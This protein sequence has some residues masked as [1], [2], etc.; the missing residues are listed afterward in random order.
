MAT[1]IKPPFTLETA[2]RK[3]RAAEDA[4]NSPGLGALGL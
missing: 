4:W 2:Q 1:P 3:A